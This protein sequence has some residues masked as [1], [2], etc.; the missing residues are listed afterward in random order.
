MWCF[1]MNSQDLTVTIPSTLNQNIHILLIKLL[2]E[3]YLNYSKLNLCQKSKNILK[4][5]D[6]TA[7]KIIFLYRCYR[8]GL[9]KK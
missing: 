1:Y 4:T 9:D 3:S 6:L 8:M 2:I 7:T 5:R